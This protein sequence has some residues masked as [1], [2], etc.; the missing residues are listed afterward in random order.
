VQ[1]ELLKRKRLLQLKACCKLMKGSKNV[2]VNLKKKHAATCAQ[3]VKNKLTKDRE[4]CK[5]LQ[6]RTIN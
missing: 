1:D 2:D 5:K 3:F 4:G 6:N